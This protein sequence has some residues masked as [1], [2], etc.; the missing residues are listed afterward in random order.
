MK[1]TKSAEICLEWSKDFQSRG[2]LDESGFW[3][4]ISAAFSSGANPL[5]AGYSEAVK[6]V[7]KRIELHE[8]AMSI[9]FDKKERKAMN[10]IKREAEFLLPKLEE[11]NK[12]THTL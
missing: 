3:M 12:E 6:E 9:I 4:A 5:G 2:H 11:L 10:Q 7:K 1:C 8:I